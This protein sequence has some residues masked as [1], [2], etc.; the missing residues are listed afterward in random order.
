MT[1][2]AT[3]ASAQNTPA[4][5]AASGAW[6]L[7]EVKRVRV[8]HLVRAKA[9]GQRNTWLTAYDALT[10][11]IFDA[12]GI[13]VLLIGDSMGNVTLGYPSPIPVTLEEIITAT[14]AVSSA[15][16]RALVVSD[17]PMGTYE[18]SPAQAHANAVRLIKEGGAHAVKLEGGVHMAPQVELL[19][20]TGIPVIGHLGFTPQSLNTIGGHLVQGRGEDAE[21]KLLAD[22]LALQEAG[23]SGVVLEMVPAPVA[24]RV[25][26]AL[27]IPTVGIGAGADCDGQVLVWSDMAGMTDWSPSFAKQ[28]AQVGAVLRQAAEDYAREVRE[29][30][31]PDADHSFQK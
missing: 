13:D 12:A 15:A 14:R 8:P 9:A 2:P 16:K 19:T 22:A 29:G 7:S 31:F 3:P 18:A 26:E 21:A 20:S 1:T 4:A 6:K 23:A 25:T 17:L 11:A 5:P 27:R 10:G 30:T 28:Y 24:A